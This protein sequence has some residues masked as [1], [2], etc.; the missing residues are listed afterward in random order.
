MKSLSLILNHLKYFAPAW[1]FASINILTGTWV[2]Y[3]PYVKNKFVINDAAI[4]MALFYMALGTLISI[5]L[6]PFINK[7]LGIG[8]STQIAVLVFALLFNLPLLAPTYWTLCLSLFCI[9]VFSGFTD[10]SMNAL[11]SIIEKE[12]KIHIMSAAHGF[13]S[14]GGV[15]GAG[16]GVLLM[17]KCPSPFWHMLIASSFIILTNLF[18]SKHYKKV[19]DEVI[20]NEKGKNVFGH[21]Y[22]LFGLA[23]IAFIVMCNEGAVEHW[24]NLFLYDVVQVS[25]SRAGLG[26]IA[27]SLCM[28]L[29]RFWGDG[30]SQQIGAR[31]II[32]YGCIIAFLAY[33]LI[34]SSTLF[35]SVIGFGLLGLGLSVI[36]PELFRLAGQMEG[37]PSSVGISIVSGV[38]FIGFLIGPVLLGFISN[39]TNLLSSYIFLSAL[40]LTAFALVF[41]QSKE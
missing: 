32:S 8:R 25:E 16:L 21:F 19:E 5:P 20:K 31:S 37:V 34:L 33:L 2:L 10:V 15:I 27:F 23:L 3:L 36:I 4:G 6:I 1:V 35:S 39:R 24:S 22:P 7:K 41:F 40:I 38:G 9:G 28:T 29:G 30:I 14:L 17:V 11:I 13:F 26:F 12:D 18:L